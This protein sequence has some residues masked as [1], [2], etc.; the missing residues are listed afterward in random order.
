MICYLGLGANLGD[1]V[2]NIRAAIER[3][4]NIDGVKLLRVSSFYETAAWGLTNQ[5][6]FINAAIKI[7]ADIEPLKLLDA[8]Q[9]IEIELGRVRH[10]HWG[11]RTID[12]DILLID[13][14]AINSPRLTI[15]HPYMYKRDFVLV[16]LSEILPTLQFKLHGDRVTKTDG[17]P[18]D[19][20]LKLV[21]CVDN[22]FGIGCNGE[23]LF[24]IPADLKHFRDLTLNHTVIYGRKTLST[25]PNNQPLDSRRNIILSRTLTAIPNAEVVNNIESLW[26]TL[27]RDDNFVIGGAEI[28][29]AL[30]PYATEIYLTVVNDSKPADAFFPSVDEFILTDIESFGNY[31]FRKY[32]REG[33]F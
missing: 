12:I 16:P 7:S 30:I 4:R 10:E 28:F 13:E 33:N 6:D 27:N 3:I 8:I 25:L 26:Q 19:F 5:P 20:K 18:V 15:P 23:L 1:R 22:N 32:L 2:N 17:S 24:K 14:L 21:A 11:A 29:N 31:E 9:Q